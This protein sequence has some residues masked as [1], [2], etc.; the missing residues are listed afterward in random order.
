MWKFDVN[1][2]TAISDNGVYYSNEELVKYM[3]GHQYHEKK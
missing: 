3:L 2:A 1:G